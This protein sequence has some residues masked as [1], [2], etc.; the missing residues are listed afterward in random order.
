MAA[1]PLML[2]FVPF[3]GQFQLG[4]IGGDGGDGGDGSSMAVDSNVRTIGPPFPLL[5]LPF[6]GALLSV[7]AG[8]V[9]GGAVSAGSFDGSDD[10]CA[11]SEVC[12]SWTG[13]D[14][15]PLA[16]EPNAG[17]VA[18][19]ASVSAIAPAISRRVHADVCLRDVAA[20]SA[21]STLRRLTCLTLPSS[22]NRLPRCALR[23]GCAV[24]VVR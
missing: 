20:D 5:P 6:P 3:G 23:I 22:P 19:P 18:N 16:F 1:L 7:A 4:Q 17:A 10:G 15:S 13:G 11:V 9:A 12:V 2:G 14:G 21:R 8:A 24:A